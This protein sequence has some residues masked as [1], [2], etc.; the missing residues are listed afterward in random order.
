MNLICIS[1][2]NKNDIAFDTSYIGSSYFLGM[3][4]SIVIFPRLSELYGRLKVIYVMVI[5]GLIS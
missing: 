1:S 4:I 3:V 5:F 2:E